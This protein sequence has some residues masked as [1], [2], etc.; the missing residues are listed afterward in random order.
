MF[1]VAVCDDEE[2]EHGWLERL[3][4]ELSN[5]TPY[6]FRLDHFFNGEDLIEH[7]LKHEPFPFHILILGI[8]MDGISGIETAQIIRSLPDHDVQIIFLAHCPEYTMTS[9]DVQPFQYLL[10]PVPCEVMTKKLIHLCQYISTSVHRFIVIKFEQEQIV[11]RVNDILA[12][13]K[14]KHNLSKN[15]LNVIT[16]QRQYIITGTMM[17]YITKL[18][19]PF[20]PIHRSVIV[21]L[22]HVRKFTAASVIMSNGDEF[23][24][25]RSQAKKFKD[26]YARHMLV[27]Q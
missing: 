3:F 6:T 26:T 15:K 12:I 20:L 18:D 23:P 21:N 19:P 24:I 16:A 10:K 17:E 14:V 7:Y 13:V 5:S 9:F 2:V 1:R 11:L 25:G 27:L 22:V 8:E 4:K